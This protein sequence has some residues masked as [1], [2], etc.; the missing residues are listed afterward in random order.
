MKKIIFVS[1][2]LPFL[3]GVKPLN[4]QNTQLD[5]LFG[6]DIGVK[7]CLD[8]GHGGN[9]NQM[10]IGV[11]K[12]FYESDGNWEAVGYL[13]TLLQKLGAQVK[14]TRTT[15]HPDSVNNNPSL[16]DRVQVANT[17]GA[18]LFLS[19]HTNA[20]STLSTNYTVIFYP[21]QYEYGPPQYPDEPLIAEILANSEHKYLRTDY[22]KAQPDLPSP[23]GFVYG[24]GIL[25]NLN[26]PGSL[27]EA[28]FHSN[29]DEARRL[30]NSTYRKSAAWAILRAYL[31]FYG[32]EQSVLG[33]GEIGG[34][35][36]DASTGET[37]NGLIVTVNPD[38]ADEKVYNGD[39]Y[40]NGFYF[41]DWL[42]TGSYTVKFEALGYV[43][44]T[45]TIDVLAGDYTETDLT[46]TAVT[47]GPVPAAPVLTS[48]INPDGGLGVAATWDANTETDLLGYRLYYAR[49][50]AMAEWVLAADE[51]T[52]TAGTTSVIVQSSHDFIVV[53]DVEHAY[54]F[55]LTA[56]SDTGAESEPSDVYSR[57]SYMVGDKILIVDGFDRTDGAYTQS[58]HNFATSY[59]MAI[60]QSKYAE[61]A[62]ASN[63]AVVAGTVNL[64]DYQLVVWF[65]GD[66]STTNETFSNQEQTIISTYLEAGGK[67][68]VSGSDIGFDLVAN[69]NTADGLFYEDYLKASYVGN[70]ANDYSPATGVTATGF[71]GLTVEFGIQY[72]VESP[73]D[74][75][76]AGE[77]ELIFSYASAGTNGG[78]AYKGTFGSGTTEGGIVY[79]SFPLETAG[80][81]DRQVTMNAILNYLQVGDFFPEPP[82]MPTLRLVASDG[83]GVTAEWVAPG[84]PARLYG[85]RL[86]Y[87]TDDNM[88]TWKLAANEQT[89][90]AGTT[91]I[92]ID[93]Y[94][95]FLEVPATDVYHYKLVAVNEGGF[96]SESSDIY[97]CRGSNSNINALIVDGFDRTNGSYSNPQHD[98]AAN[99]FRGMQG[100]GDFSITTAVNEKLLNNALDITSYDMIFWFF[101][102]ESSTTTTLSV[103]DQNML[104]EFL[105][106]G[107]KLFISGSEVGWDLV[108]KGNTTDKAFYNNYLKANFTGD[109]GS[110]RSP[111][112]GVAGTDFADLVVEFGITYIENYP[113]EISARD[114][115]ENILQ[116]ANSKYGGIAYTGTFGDGVI[117]GSVVYVSFT[118]ETAV[119]DDID[120]T[121]AKVIDYFGVFVPAAPVASDDVASA[122]LGT[123]VT[124]DVLAN[125]WDINNDMDSTS[126]IIVDQP[127]YG[128]ASVSNNQILYTQDQGA[129]GDESFTYKVTDK[130]GLWSNVATMTLSVST[131][132]NAVNDT[133]AFYI[134]GEPIDVLVN[135]W[136]IN[137][138]IDPAT[139]TI[140]D[141][142]LGGTAIVTN[143]KIVYHP[144]V[145]LGSNNYTHEDSLTYKILDETGLESNTAMV[146]ISIDG[147]NGI[148]DKLSKSDFSLYPNPGYDK[149]ILEIKES[150]N[151]AE[152]WSITVLD[153]SGRVIDHK[154]H[155]FMESNLLDL[156]ISHFRSG[157]YYVM[158]H[159]KQ[160]SQTLKLIKK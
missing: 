92:N 96:E 75:A 6:G 29:W 121:M 126:I 35:I 51:R 105:Q 144:Y 91:S 26:M 133:I 7:F 67:M 89:L 55:K 34:I 112:T 142:P 71:E 24:Y 60:R 37:I 73:D 28:S 134:I 45:R 116:Y 4:A 46:L 82:N 120:A 86:Y 130:S 3:F 102:D 118:L 158:I 9:Y 109:G 101:G 95:Q 93:Q 5:T 44:E 54:H 129:T 40:L 114:G 30:L 136:D 150:S 79:M 160:I 99:Y 58:Q 70:G 143:E 59:F 90:S 113:D 36:T 149:V 38:E 43:S 32:Y 16:S 76:A 87:A 2:V 139:I 146:R 11:G 66:E 8:P 145:V 33:V 19:Y 1:L 18:D 25:N 77:S 68:A 56:V 97:S 12:Y 135:D 41:F 69:G 63:E 61:V 49:N 57:S 53:P 48:I 72:T 153:Y 84:D 148:E 137:N 42:T 13:D 151:H 85:Y 117:P 108:E 152:Q 10:E 157:V 155:T 110:G 17:F 20:S 154:K 156:N 132:P 39:Y 159:N 128:I 15:N 74:I 78:V 115:S 21:V 23:R 104:K 127:I 22:G 65:V 125:D 103:S 131:P 111:A 119:Q 83:D 100:S 14:I 80:I 64:A 47:P 88:N 147:V 27:S 52:L 124:I 140:V 141:E 106:G 138:D 107:G 122:M 62:T 123:Q 98:F 94:S 81:S 31:E 50:D